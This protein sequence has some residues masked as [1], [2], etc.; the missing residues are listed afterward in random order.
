[1]GHSPGGL[2]STAAAGALSCETKR[3]YCPISLWAYLESLVC[4][5]YI[6][7]ASLQALHS[8]NGVIEGDYDYL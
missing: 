6:D 8:G 7:M 2:L 1:M 4:P 3:N 5:L